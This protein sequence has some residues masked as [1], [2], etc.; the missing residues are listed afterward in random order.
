MPDS[1]MEVLHQSPPMDTAPDHPK[2]L[3]ARAVGE[4]V[5]GRCPKLVHEHFASDARY[6]SAAG[7]PALCLGPSGAGMHADDEQLSLASLRDYARVI[8]VLVMEM[9]R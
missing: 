8:D 4:R 9:A 5:L 6:Y 1:V 3:Q 7:T 2:L